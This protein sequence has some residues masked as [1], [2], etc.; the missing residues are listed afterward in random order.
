M[1]REKPQG[2]IVEYFAELEDPRWY[3]KQHKLLDILAI[4]ICAAMC[5]ANGWQDKKGVVEGVVEIATW[6]SFR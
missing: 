2:A 6:H 1:E 5:G 4:A 3:N